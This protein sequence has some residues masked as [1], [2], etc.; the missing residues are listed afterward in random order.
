M[1]NKVLSD[2]VFL[3]LYLDEEEMFTPKDTFSCESGYDGVADDI[4]FF[5]VEQGASPVPFWIGD[6]TTFDNPSAASAALL[7]TAIDALLTIDTIGGGVTDGDKGDITVSGGG[8]V[9][10]IDAGLGATKIADGSV[11]NTEFQYLGNVTSDI[12]TQLNAKLDDSQFDG[13]AKITV[14]TTTPVG[15]ATGDLWVDTN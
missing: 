8:A 7:K 15:P 4:A 6:Y 1:A 2:G 14:G 9:W 13:L 11:T 3:Q 12:Q 5:L 10:T